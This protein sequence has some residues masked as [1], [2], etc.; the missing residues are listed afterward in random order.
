MG[1]FCQRE[2]FSVSEANIPHSVAWGYTGTPQDI[3][4]IQVSNPG[5]GYNWVQDSGII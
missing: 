5:Y 4:V 3:H 2:P 1:G